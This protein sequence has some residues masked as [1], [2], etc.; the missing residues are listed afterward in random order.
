MRRSGPRARGTL[1]LVMALAALAACGGEQ[2][3]G[4]APAP[5]GSLQVTVTGLPGGIDGRVTVTGPGGYSDDLAASAQLDGLAE[6]AY[7]IAPDT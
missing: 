6:G 3:G 2:K 1:R 4:A 7:L 5:V